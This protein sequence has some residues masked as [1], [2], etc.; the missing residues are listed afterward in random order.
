MLNI[1]IFLL[2]FITN[3]I[4]LLSY[5]SIFQ[6][7]SGLILFKIRNINILSV[8]GL[9][10]IIS[11]L[12]HMFS[13]SYKYIIKEDYNL[14]Y[15][16]ESQEVIIQACR[17][18]I[19]IAFFFLIGVTTKIHVKIIKT[20][21]EISDK[22]LE[23]VGWI[24]LLI[25][26]IPRISIDYEKIRISMSRGYLASYDVNV[27][28]RGT[29]ATLV[30]TGILYLL[31]AKREKKSFCRVLLII[32]IIYSIVG[33]LSGNRYIYISV[34]ICIM[35]I[36]FRYVERLGKKQIVLGFSFSYLF[37]ALLGAIRETRVTGISLNSFMKSFFSSIESNPLVD[38]F[39][40]MGGTMHTVVLS[41]YNF[42]Q[43][44]SYA[45]GRTYLYFFPNIIPKVQWG[46]DLNHLTYIKQFPIHAFLGGSY[47][48]ELY[49]NFGFFGCFI[50]FFLGRFFYSID[51]KT[52]SMD[53][54]S[55]Y[56]MALFTP[57]IL[58]TIFYIRGY[59]QDYRIAVY[60]AFLFL[61]LKFFFDRKKVVYKF[62]KESK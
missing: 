24:F 35:F 29:I 61:I 31:L 37:F 40:E 56:T 21:E 20:K 15:I 57:F 54:K 53:K 6:L 3:D 10:Y 34:L 60:H 59:F 13:I 11:Y 28:G 62:P 18:Y 16:I 43:H 48:G 19:C 36:Y 32:S 49:Y 41:I 22:T 5:F 33:M 50:T 14:M 26:I 17:F 38:I 25:G 7:I 27:S 39:L 44:V 45:W 12:F 9:F 2:C 58:Y 42:P 30:Y 23:K 47:I 46:F 55:I 52:Q 51:I 8:S 1:C 4:T